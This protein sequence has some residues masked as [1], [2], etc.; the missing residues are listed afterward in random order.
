M[1]LI[2]CPECNK[3]VSDKAKVCIQCG[4]PL[5]KQ[6]YIN[7]DMDIGL[8]DKENVNQTENEL[9]MENSN[10]S[11]KKGN[12]F[13]SLIVASLIIVIVMS[14]LLFNNLYV[15][16]NRTYNN[17]MKLYNTQS[18]TDALPL[19]ESLENFKDSNEYVT[20]IIAINKENEYN[21]AVSNINSQDIDKMIKAEQILEG[22][23]NYKDSEKY[24]QECIKNMA[25]IY[26]DNGDIEKA[27]EYCEKTKDIDNDEEFNNKYENI[28]F[29]SSISGEW[30]NTDKSEGLLI[31]GLNVKLMTFKI[32]ST[33]TKLIIDSVT[34][35]LL[36]TDKIS[37][38]KTSIVTNNERLGTVDLK[39]EGDVLTLMLMNYNFY[40]Y[41]YS[42]YDITSNLAQKP[43]IGMT[44][45]E[46]RESTWGKPYE[47][48]KDTYSW[49]TNE[50]WCYDNYKYIYLENGIV[51]SISQ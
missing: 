36:S 46:V 48:N 11:T 13:K 19:F 21:V 51:T 20:K 16:K 49:G 1:A 8:L 26:L 10:I 23:G 2:K 27:K 37:K 17:A 24:L 35:F 31:D 50:Q 12:D 47:I 22:I 9:D 29:L 25:I 33:S 39:V 14:L 38:N 40:K 44:A 7:F 3:E 18:F 45:Q 32:S 28:K 6:S 30:I 41:N 5:D 43:S 34:S 42:P 4:Y 15:S